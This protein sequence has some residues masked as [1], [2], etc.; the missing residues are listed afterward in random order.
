MY[1]FG[2]APS[3]DN[4]KRYVFKSVCFFHWS[5]FW[6]DR[7]QQPRVSDSIGGLTVRA[8]VNPPREPRQ[9]S[10]PSDARLLLFWCQPVFVFQG[11]CP[12]LLFQDFLVLLGDHLTA[13]CLVQRLREPGR[14]AGE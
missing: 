6:F 11:R 14:N 3:L 10:P 12:L 8:R 4:K 13:G 1:R 2:F 9:K 5:P 7:R